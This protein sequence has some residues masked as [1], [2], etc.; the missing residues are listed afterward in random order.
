MPDTIYLIYLGTED[1]WRTVYRSA[2]VPD[3]AAIQAQNPAITLYG[4]WRWR[5]GDHV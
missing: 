5:A 1:D 2:G 3:F 4:T